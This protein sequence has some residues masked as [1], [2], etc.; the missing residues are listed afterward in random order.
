MTGIE[1][2]F[3]SILRPVINIIAFTP[4]EE[5]LISSTYTQNTISINETVVFN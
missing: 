2:V 1:E 5:I 4:A 3:T